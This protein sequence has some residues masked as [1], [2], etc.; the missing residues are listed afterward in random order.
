[1]SI[2]RP[3]NESET[4]LHFVQYVM[5]DLKFEILNVWS[6]FPDATVFYGGVE[7]KVEFEYKLSSFIKHGHNPFRC[8]FVICWEN[9]VPEFPLT[10]WEL[11]ENSYPPIA[12][13]DEEKLYQFYE[14]IKKKK[15][16]KPYKSAEVSNIDWSNL[17]E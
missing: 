6:I 3:T 10:V 17:K 16:R 14:M 13:P 5:Q 4:I 7:Y 8:N 2:K 11:S 15:E 9:D 1:M 12:L